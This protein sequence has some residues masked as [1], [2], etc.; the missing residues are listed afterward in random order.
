MNKAPLSDGTAAVLVEINNRPL[1]AATKRIAPRPTPAADQRLER[2]L[3]SVVAVEGASVFSGGGGAGTSAGA[4]GADVAEGVITSD[5]A[6]GAGGLRSISHSS[7]TAARSATGTRTK[8]SVSS[9]GGGR[10]AARGTAA[11]N[12]AGE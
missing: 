5:G 1:T 3:G 12:R 8:W 10:P 6:E 9:S 7:L 2:S 4:A 11:P